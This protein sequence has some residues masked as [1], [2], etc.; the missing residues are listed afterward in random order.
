MASRWSGMMKKMFRELKNTPKPI[1][2]YRG[3]FWMN[4]RTSNFFIPQ[5]HFL[6]WIYV[7]WSQFYN[8]LTLESDK[9]SFFSKSKDDIKN[10]AQ[11]ALDIDPKCLW[12]QW[13]LLR[14]WTEGSI[15]FLLG[16]KTAFFQAK[17]SFHSKNMVFK[18]NFECL[19]CRNDI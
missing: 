11:K 14:T 10:L 8:S 4:L 17:S 16:R 19:K 15:N 12:M 2:H 13:L 18:S 6:H 9:I 3:T 5:S 1:L 7:F